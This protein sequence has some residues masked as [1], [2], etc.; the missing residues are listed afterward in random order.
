[1]PQPSFMQQR[2]V[3][4]AAGRETSLPH[5]PGT[6]MFPPSWDEAWE[7]L[8]TM[9]QQCRKLLERSDDLDLLPGK[10]KMMLQR[11][12]TSLRVETELWTTQVARVREAMDDSLGILVKAK[13]D[14][15]KMRGVYAAE[16]AELDPKLTKKL[17]D[18]WDNLR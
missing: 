5:F 6:E 18:A 4:Q 1:M 11:L 16:F 3:K 12:D 10:T 7:V 2:I 14:L 13:K 8:Q 15:I 9:R 17:F